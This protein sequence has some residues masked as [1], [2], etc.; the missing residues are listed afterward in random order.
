VFADLV[1]DEVLR[2]APH[3]RARLRPATVLVVAG[4]IH[5]VTRWLDGGVPL[6]RVELVEEIT[7][8]GTRALLA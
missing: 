6:G 8:V 5:L 7:R 2:V 4:T 3:D 1:L